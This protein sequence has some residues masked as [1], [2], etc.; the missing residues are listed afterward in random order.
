[1]KL[2][3]IVCVLLGVLSGIFSRSQ[4][5]FG[6]IAEFDRT[7]HDFGDV[8]LSDGALR[9]SFSVKNISEKPIVI[10]SVTTSC[11]CTD[12]EWSRQ[13]LQPGQSGKISVTYTNDEGPYSFDK[14]LTVH[15]S[16]IKQPIVLKLRGSSHEKKMSPE[17][18]YK[19][20][21]GALGMK[22]AD[23]KCG[24]IQVG[25]V[26]TD[27]VTVAN[28]SGKPLKVEF[29]DV[30]EGLSLKLSPNPIPAGST[31]ILRYGVTG[32]R[33][34]WG[35]NNYYATPVV[36]GARHGKIS[37]YAF[38]KENFD[39]M[40]AEERK[41]AARPMFESS[42]FSFGKMSRGGIVEASFTVTNQ[43]KSDFIVYKT[44]IDSGR[45]TATAFPA[46]KPGE[47]KGFK[48]KMDTSSLPLGETLVIV[49]LTT[50]SPSRPL[51]NLFITGWLTD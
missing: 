21:F 43:G 15:I 19:V 10:Y 18:L 49:T 23:L 7:V 8:L 41:N 26:R 34:I 33:G 36:N 1:M 45:G 35:K 14:S 42:T 29:A 50:N 28:L 12:V 20:R 39:D 16:G 48:V 40:T 9:C 3:F 22:S 31:A 5:R 38:T 27:E 32:I 46:V 4:E 6:N 11:G 47:K 24:N 17:E 44:D 51:I 25:G 30:S 13:P 2:K 37:V